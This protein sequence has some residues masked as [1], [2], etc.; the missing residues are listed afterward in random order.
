MKL[1]FS[2]VQVVIAAFTFILFT[3]GSCSKETSQNGNPQQEEQ[4]SL[5]SS[6]SDG[7]AEMVFNEVFDDAMGVNDEVG[8]A[9]T[10]IF[11]RNSYGTSINT[12][13]PGARV[14]SLPHCVSVTI[15]HTNAPAIFPV[16]VVIDFGT[17]GCPGPDGHIRRGKIINEYTNRLVVPGAIATSTFDGFYIDSI[18]VEGTHRITNTST[19]NVRQFTVDVIAAKLSKP[20]GN[21]TEWASH[22]TITQIEGLGTPDWPRDDI[23]KIEGS[24]H[25]RA[26]RGDL[27]VVWESSIVEPL[28]KKFECRWVV[29]GRVRT[30]RVTNSTTANTWIAVLDFGTG[31]CD[32][33]ATITINGVVHQ[34]TLH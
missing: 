23:F 15:T 13:N 2:A 3:I 8:M 10:G 1:R 18:K 16:R 11:G 14:D 27:L 32:N 31:N 17:S 26:K 30:V 6:E 5:A 20:N 33:Q 28:I 19:S 22:K 29:Q 4:A 12:I 21:Y 24:A 25:G 34:I 7:E 9:G